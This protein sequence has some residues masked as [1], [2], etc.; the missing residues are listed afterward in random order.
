MMNAL[1]LIML[2]YEIL[3]NPHHGRI[4]RTALISGKAAA[5]YEAAK[6]IIRLINCISRKINHDPVVSKVL[7]VVYVENYNVSHAEIMIPA[8]DLS[9]Q[10]STAGTEASGTGNMK[11]AMNG[12]L[13]I[14][15]DDGANIE[16]RQE[17]TDAWWPFRFGAS[18]KEI[19]QMRASGQYRPQSIL[20]AN[21]KI[22]R[23]V[24]SLLNG[25]FAHSEDEH[26]ALLDLYNKLMVSHYG[27]PPD[28]YFTLYD[29]PSYYEAQKKVETLYQDPEKW[30]EYAIHNIAGM[31]KFSTDT[32][33]DNYAK[34]VWDLT[35]CPADEDIL[36]RFRNEFNKYDKCRIY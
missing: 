4:K 2:Y 9:E 21:P 25:D 26:K 3:E 35:P 31:G 17:I 6:N 5:G 15:T 14:G 18:A 36:D 29:L 33:I 8:A 32:S 28:H 19:S 20:D 34:L 24:E 22:K 13:T 1:H 7:K 16:M 10:I 30:A 23:A 12:A 11:L 27:G